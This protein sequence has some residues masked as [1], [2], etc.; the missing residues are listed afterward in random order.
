MNLLAE[1]SRDTCRAPRNYFNFSPS[2]QPSGPEQEDRLEDLFCKV[3]FLAVAAGQTEFAQLAQTTA[4]FDAL[5]QALMQGPKRLNPPMLR[6]LGSLVD[7]V[8]LLL[9]LAC[10]SLLRTPLSAR[11]LVV[12]DDPIAN[13]MVV[14]A[15]GQAQIDVCSAEDPVMAWQLI[16]G[17]Q[18]DLVLLDIETS[19]LN[20]W[21]LCKRLR[22]VP[23][24]EKTPVI[25]F[26]SHDN[27]DSRARSTLSGAD[28]LIAKP[29]P[30][31]GTGG[32]SG[33]AFG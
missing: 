19:V 6:T 5:L 31:P 7:L 24:Y 11:V 23:G 20:G 32:Q 15:L 1:A 4:V 25:V 16:N 33:D 3:H 14:G 8:G 13:Q 9:Q 2:E 12:T 17:E 10:D 26:S 30:A 28:D 18:F 22:S 29:F 27:I 21:E